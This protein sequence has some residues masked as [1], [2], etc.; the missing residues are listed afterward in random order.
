MAENK[1]E[2]K[3][4]NKE[5]HPSNKIQVATKKN[6]SF[7]VFLSKR[8]LK[9]NNEIELSGLGNAINNVVSCAEILKNNGFATVKKIETSL[10]D[11]ESQTRSKPIQKAKI[12]IF[13]NKTKDCD[14]LIKKEEEARAEQK[15]REE[16]QKKKELPQE[17]TEQK[18]TTSTTQP[19][20]K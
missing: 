7:Y 12:Q 8:F 15:K 16:E 13:L 11:V 19:Q 5:Q 1:T 6:L 2:T 4:Q 10:V 17:G 3:P 20:K 14:A 18:P 9:E